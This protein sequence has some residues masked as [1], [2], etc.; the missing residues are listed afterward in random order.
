MRVRIIK[1]VT[2]RINQPLTKQD[3]CDACGAEAK[4]RVTLDKGELLFCQHHYTKHSQALED[5]QVDIDGEN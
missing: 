3:R 4:V 2:P 1:E 5:K